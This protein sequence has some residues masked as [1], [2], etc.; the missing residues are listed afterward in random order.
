M[1]LTDLQAEQFELYYREMVDWN[2]RVNLTAITDYQDVQRKHFLDSLTVTLAIKQP[3]TAHRMKVIDVGTGAGMPG[4]PLKIIWPQIRLTLLE[5]TRKKTQFLDYL[6]PKLGLTGVEIVAGRAED[7]AHTEQHREAYD[8][9]LSRAVA[10]LPVLLELTLPF[11]RTGGTFVAQKQIDARSEVE[12][13]RRAAALLG[14]KFMEVRDI[15]LPGFQE[16]CLM[17]Y[18]KMAPT[19]AGYP[20]RPGTPAKKP[21]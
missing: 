6:S 5:A 11:C 21:L 1:R 18:G 4:I 9:V 15:G 12:M 13:A 2:R 3:E 10:P 14:G 19:P 16:R 7:V 17:V 8:V 20:R